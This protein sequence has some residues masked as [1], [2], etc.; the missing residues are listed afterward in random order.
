MK[1]PVDGVII[2]FLFVIIISTIGCLLILILNF[3]EGIVIGDGQVAFPLI[4][5]AMGIV[6]A[7]AVLLPRY[8]IKEQIRDN[9]ENETKN[10][11]NQ[12]LNLNNQVLNLENQIRGLQGEKTKFEG[13]EKTIDSLSEKIDSQLKSLYTK[14]IA[15]NQK[16]SIKTD[17]HLSRIAA[18]SLFIDKKYYWSLGWSFR[19][20]KR[21]IK[22]SYFKYP[23]PGKYKK[24]I[25]SLI[26]L[27]IKN[28]DQIQQIYNQAK[29]QHI[30]S[31]VTDLLVDMIKGEYTNIQDDNEILE[32]LRDLCK[33]IYDIY[34]NLSFDNKKSEI[35]DETARDILEL[36]N[37]RSYII[38]SWI[39]LLIEKKQ[40]GTVENLVVEIRQGSSYSTNPDQIKKYKNLIS[41]KFNTI[42]QEDNKQKILN[43]FGSSIADAKTKG[44]LLDSTVD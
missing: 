24:Y 27:I 19:A 20:L 44:E 2:A 11:N 10:L 21:Y 36:I 1:K 40:E 38:Q 26:S 32:T 33:D 9:V 34:Y 4:I 29:K 3:L 42:Y 22:L 5:S 39:C 31:K 14:E 16:E 35:D 13:F 18:Y 15:N 12:V 8:T 37:N 43:D 7:T 23:S 17:A 28:I 6:L 41:K 25:K 30:N